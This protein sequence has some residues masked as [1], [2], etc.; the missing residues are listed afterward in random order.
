M[1]VGFYNFAGFYKMKIIQN[2][3]YPHPNFSHFRS[4]DIWATASD[5]DEYKKDGWIGRY[6]DYDMPAFVDAQPT[7]PPALQIGV[8]TD[9]VFQGQN[10]NLALAISSP[11]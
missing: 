6:I 8:Q 5:T 1:S 7:V 9:L 4:S 10:T 11:N 2:V 3:G